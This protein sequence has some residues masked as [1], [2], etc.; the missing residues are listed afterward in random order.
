MFMF[1]VVQFSDPGY[2]CQPKKLD[3]L[4]LLETCDP[5]KLCPECLVV[6]TPR[7]F[8]CTTCNQ[9]VE[10]YDHHCPWINNCIGINNHG[11]FLTF[12]IVL[13]T[14]ISILLITTTYNYMQM[15]KEIYL[16]DPDGQQAIKYI[17]FRDTLEPYILNHKFI[18]LM[19]IICL[20]LISFF[21]SPINLMLYIQTKI[22]LKNR[23]TKE[24]YSRGRKQEA[25][26]KQER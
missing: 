13:A 16:H 23:T 22:F 10:R 2:I 19:Y 6:K 1:F 9:C 24:Q 20:L 8:H 21:F 14:N 18:S 3:F 15:P 17:L 25:P 11:R 26:K 5:I 4:N 7:S 12:I